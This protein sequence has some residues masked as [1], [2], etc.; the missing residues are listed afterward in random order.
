[1]FSFWKRASPYPKLRK[2]QT[3]VSPTTVPFCHFL[4]SS[5]SAS[6]ICF[7]SRLSLPPVSSSLLHFHCPVPGHRP[8]S[9][10]PV[11]S[12]LMALLL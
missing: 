1:M 6:P 9:S 10:G 11:V 3:Q 12:L 8:L 7:T 4:A 2:P 5:S